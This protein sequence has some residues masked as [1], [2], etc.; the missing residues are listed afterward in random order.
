VT[1]DVTFR[2]AT[3][4]DKP[5]ILAIAAQVWEGDDYV[6][7]VIDDWLAEPDADLVA[8]CVGDQLVAFARYDRVLPRHAWFEGLRTDPAWQNRGLGKAMT[9]HLLERARADGMARV[10]LST[11]FDNLASQRVTESHG[12]SRVAGFVYCEAGQ[13]SPARAAAA[14]CEEIEVISR[15]EAA[16]FILH[17]LFMA[18]AQSFLPHSWR[19]Y[20]FTRA[21]QVALSRMARVFGIRRNGALAALLCMGAAT[22][23]PDAASIDFLDGDPALLPRLARHALHLAGSARHVES[24]M[25]CW[26][27]VSAP[28]VAVLRELGFTVWNEGQEDVYIYERSLVEEKRGHRE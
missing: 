20:P 21:P 22:H 1:L 5:A 15:N 25:P 10:G 28:A 17:S 6:P 13:D 3:P 11:Y 27:G 24:M 9:A 19:F 18:A 14:V 26:N 12:F 4:A 23:G 16:A 7:D 2:P 8:A